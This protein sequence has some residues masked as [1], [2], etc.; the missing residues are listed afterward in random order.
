VQLLVEGPEDD[1][2]A[3]PAEDLE[4]FV[5]ADPAER[6]RPSQRPQEREGF[7]RMPAGVGDRRA[8]Q[9]LGR[10]SVRAGGADGGAGEEAAGVVVRAE[11]RFDAGAQGRVLAATRSR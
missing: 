6:I 8:A 3:A 9:F 2:E 7:V 4:G 1:A 5:M 11:Q 10:P